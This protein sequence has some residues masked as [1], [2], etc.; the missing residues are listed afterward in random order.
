[1]EATNMP[2]DSKNG[3]H[4]PTFSHSFLEQAI[5]SRACTK[6][7]DRF[8]AFPWLPQTAFLVVPENGPRLRH[9]RFGQI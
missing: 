2:E 7:R 8:I 6:W 4:F 1:M 9:R 3:R 5:F